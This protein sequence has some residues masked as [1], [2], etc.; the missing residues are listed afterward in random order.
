[1]SKK[2]KL[3]FELKFEQRPKIQRFFR[4]LIDL[5]QK[6]N[7]DGSQDVTDG[8]FFVLWDTPK[9]SKA[10]PKE[11]RSR[12]TRAISK[13]KKDLKRHFTKDK[14]DVTADMYIH[15][16]MY[17]VLGFNIRDNIRARLLKGTDINMKWSSRDKDKF[18]LEKPNK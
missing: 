7:L 10:I 6:Y 11:L 9:N 8:R 12:L 13:S 15:D 16:V 18:T 4:W 14:W 3:K 5:I 1:M 2:K 17:D